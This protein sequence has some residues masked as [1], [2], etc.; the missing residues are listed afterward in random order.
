VLNDREMS[1]TELQDVLNRVAKLFP[2]GAVIIR[3]DKKAA[4]GQAVSILNCCAN[5]DI[6]NV[7]FAALPEEAGGGKK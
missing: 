7:S 4:L 6:S 3:G 1:M 5:A 2:G